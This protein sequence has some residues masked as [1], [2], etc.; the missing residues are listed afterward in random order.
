MAVELSDLVTQLQSDVPAR[1]SVPSSAQ[2]TQAVKDAVRDL[3][4]RAPMQQVVTLSIVSGTATYALPADFLK[5]IRLTALSSPTGVIVTG[6]G[7][8]PVSSSFC[9]KWTING[10]NIRFH[11]TP[12]YTL[13]R[14]LWYAAA[15]VLDEDEIYQ[16]LS[17][18]MAQ[19]AMLRARS[20][21]LHLQANKAAPL[22]IRLKAG[23]DDVDRTKVA[24]ALRSEAKAWETQYETAV[25]RLTGPVG[26]RG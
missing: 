3:S 26:M 22:S 8:I 19:I 11:P 21:A 13:E 24:E 1:D 7:L 10:A 15:Y 14:E 4:R 16:G 25:E 18:D 17:E 12:T 5:L 6:D 23:D 9:E 2:Y 20:T